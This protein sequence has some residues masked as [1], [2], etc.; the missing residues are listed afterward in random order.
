[1]RLTL[2]SE[3][4]TIA[5]GERLGRRLKP[6]SVV[7]LRGELGAGKTTLARGLARGAGYRGRVSSPTFA[8][9]HAYRGK[10]L[11][12]H[13][14]DLYR[15]ARGEDSEI[16]LDELLADPRG[17]VVVEWPDAAGGLW[18]KDRL[19]VTLSHVSGGRRA[20]LKATGPRARALQS[21]RIGK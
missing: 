20:A 4:E 18:P 17:A 11:T 3:E 16:G 19:E 21:S 5:L 9:A 6:G 12:V 15:V 10:R 1:M 13:H 8:L 7:L 2:S 14:L